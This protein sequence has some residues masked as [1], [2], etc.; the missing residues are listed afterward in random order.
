MPGV[1]AY[2]VSLQYRFSYHQQIRK[3]EY[4]ELLHNEKKETEELKN[5]ARFQQQ[6]HRS[7]MRAMK[8]TLKKMDVKDRMILDKYRIPH[9]VLEFNHNA[10]MLGSGVRCERS[11]NNTLLARL[12][13]VH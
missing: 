3:L 2:R 13:T 7:E 4:E 9:K 6:M 1:A 11:K 12:E 8:R 5:E 10:P